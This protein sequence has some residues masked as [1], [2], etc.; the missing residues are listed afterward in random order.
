MNT[1]SALQ[2]SR[3]IN[4]LR[5]FIKKL[6]YDSSI[7][8]TSL[9]IA[10]EHSGEKDAAEH[11]AEAITARTSINIPAQRQQQSAGDVLFLELLKEVVEEE[12]GLY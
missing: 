1:T 10:R 11:I 7:L 2:Q 9:A 8:D 6:L 4:E 5:S 12:Q 3:T